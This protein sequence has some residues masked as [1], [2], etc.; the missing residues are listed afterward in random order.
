VRKAAEGSRRQRRPIRRIQGVVPQGITPF[1]FYGEGCESV[2]GW[3]GIGG[4]MVFATK[5]QAAFG[6]PRGTGVQP[7][8]VNP[9]KAMLNAE[10]DKKVGDNRATI[11]DALFNSLIKKGNMVSAKLL[12]ALA[13]GRI[14]CEDPVVMKKL[15]RYA[16]RLA[17]EPELTDVEVEALTENEL[18]EDEPED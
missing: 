18:D 3:D 13:D 1:P 8:A 9:G 14:N 5:R 7:Q 6:K 11:V 17:S 10:A 15:C 12:F 4:E 16:A 2:E